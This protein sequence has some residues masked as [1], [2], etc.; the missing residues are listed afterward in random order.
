MKNLPV[1]IVA[2]LLTA[3]TFAMPVPNCGFE[4]WNNYSGDQKIQKT[5]KET[6]HSGEKCLMHWKGT[7]QMF[8]PYI[9]VKP[10]TWYRIR[11]FCRVTAQSGDISFGIRQCVSTERDTKSVKYNWFSI[12]L[13]VPEWKEY[14]R[15]FKTA[16]KTHGLS[17]YFRCNDILGGEGHSPCQI[18]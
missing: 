8:P 13:N 4:G 1:F 7:T 6:S 12:K 16:S 17:I 5:T 14:V 15:E 2:L 9:P 18:V 10:D 11:L 3:V